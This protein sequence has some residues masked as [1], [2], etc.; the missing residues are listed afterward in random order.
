[1]TRCTC[2]I[3][4]RYG[5]RWAYCTQKTATVSCDPDA[6]SAY[7]W[8]DESLEF[9]FC[10]N[11]GCLTHYEDVKKGEDRRV[12]INARMMAPEEIAS[13][14][15]KTFDGADTWKYLDD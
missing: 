15:I 8:G 2:S 1:M 10:K 13:V 9:F 12:A 5:A 4:H 14:R 11:C 6:I 3:C 7:R